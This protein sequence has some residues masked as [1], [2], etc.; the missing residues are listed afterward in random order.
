MSSTL[1]DVEENKEIFKAQ[2]VAEIAYRVLMLL[3]SILVR[4]GLEFTTVKRTSVNLL[5]QICARVLGQV[6]KF[7]VENVGI[8]D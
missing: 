5:R 3:P 7:L 8:I 4:D 1:G 2:Y 6:C